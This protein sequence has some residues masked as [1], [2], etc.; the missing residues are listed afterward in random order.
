MFINNIPGPVGLFYTKVG[1]DVDAKVVEI[2]E[3][4]ADSG[5]T[6]VQV[7]KTSDLPD[8]LVFALCS[9]RCTLATVSKQNYIS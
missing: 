4:L 1:D 3:E 8:R 2:S 6:G 7:I 9:P 5:L